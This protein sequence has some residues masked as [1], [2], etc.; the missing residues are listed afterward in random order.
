MECAVNLFGWVLCSQNTLTAYLISI[1]KLERTFENMV[2]FRVET[3]EFTIQAIPKVFPTYF[4]N[5]FL[6][7]KKLIDIV[8]ENVKKKK[9]ELVI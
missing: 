9:K 7:R 1:Y 2:H 6:R 3:G 4:L 5:I 8:G